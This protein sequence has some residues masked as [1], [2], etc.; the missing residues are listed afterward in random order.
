M[1]VRLSGSFCK[2]KMKPANRRTGEPVNEIIELSVAGSP[3]R[4]LAGYTLRLSL[5]LSLDRVTD[6]Q[7]KAL[8]QRRNALWVNLERVS[9]GK[10]PQGLWRGAP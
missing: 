9:F 5:V 1:R 8:E 7:L 10:G 4:R 3:V 6:A 2:A